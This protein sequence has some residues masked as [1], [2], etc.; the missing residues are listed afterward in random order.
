[1]LAPQPALDFDFLGLPTNA[2]A[3]A[4]LEK[5]RAGRPPG[6]RN[7]RAEHQAR[8]AVQAFDSPSIQLLA[9]GSL[10][11]EALMRHGLTFKEAMEEK[12]LNLTAAAPYFDQKKPI[13]VEHAGALPM[14]VMADPRSFTVASMVDGDIEEIQDL[15]EV[16][17][18]PV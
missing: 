18:A 1:V 2:G 5:R 11:V 17:D 6:S 15:S 3:E 13:A 12:R 7:K 4:V 8:L 14:L 9:M 16:P 10:P